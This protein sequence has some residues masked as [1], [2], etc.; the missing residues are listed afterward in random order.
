MIQPTD[1]EIR[2]SLEEH[3][4]EIDGQWAFRSHPMNVYSEKQALTLTKVNL[5]LGTIPN[6]S[7]STEMLESI[8]DRIARVERYIISGQW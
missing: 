8:V 3:A 2:S 7:L 1:E 6:G 5:M 4:V